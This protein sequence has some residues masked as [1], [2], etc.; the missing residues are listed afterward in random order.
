VGAKNEILAAGDIVICRFLLR[1]EGHEGV[2]APSGLTKHGM[3]QC[4][5]NKD[6]KMVSAEMVFDVMGFMQQFQVCGP[7]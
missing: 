5:F 1:S 7:C 4:K 6:N 3:L 2:G